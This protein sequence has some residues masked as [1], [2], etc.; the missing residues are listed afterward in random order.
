MAVEGTEDPN[1]EPAQTA[2]P[3]PDT[4]H[5]F[6]GK[7]DSVEELEKAYLE[8][9][10]ALHNPQPQGDPQG[11]P[12]GEPT[13]DAQ[14]AE[15]ISEFEQKFVSQG[16]QLTDED[17]AAL[18][19]RGFP[20]AVVDSYIT[21]Q[22]A[23]AEQA[24]ERIYSQIGGKETYERLSQWVA[25]ALPPE[26]IQALNQKIAEEWSAG[27]EDNIVLILKGLLSDFQAKQGPAGLDTDPATRM[28]GVQPYGSMEELIADQSKPEYKTDPAFRE[29]VRRRLAA[30]TNLLQ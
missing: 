18:E 3:D 15:V 28:A 23:L 7:F 19:Q 25:Q 4:Q 20:R 13:G 11:E 22:A 12:A 10:R 29:H 6:A 2:P 5:K 17:Y 21:G 1:T 16:G 14:I 30:S 9:Q 26:K 24:Y 27:N 8:A